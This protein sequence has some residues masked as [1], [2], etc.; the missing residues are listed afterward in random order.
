M[1][2]AV[3]GESGG[4]ISFDHLEQQ[5]ELGARARQRHPVSGLTG[6]LGA[7]PRLGDH[8]CIVGESRGNLRR[9]FDQRRLDRIF[10]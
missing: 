9:E 10:E 7:P 4:E 5:R 6:R 2:R 1:R 8:R 3:L